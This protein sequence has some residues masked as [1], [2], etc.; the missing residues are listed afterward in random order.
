MDSVRS[1]LRSQA[2]DIDRLSAENADQQT[3]VKNLRT[4]VA[5]L[6][7]IQQA[8]AQD[9]IH[10]AGRLLAI[11]RATGVDLDTTTKSLFR[12]RGWTAARNQDGQKP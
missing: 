6:K 5:R 11:A 4:D 9:L 12:R 1:Q 8:D 10:I 7:A 3:I 2:T